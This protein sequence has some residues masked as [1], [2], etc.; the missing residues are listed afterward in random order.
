MIEALLSVELSVIVGDV[1]TGIVNDN[2]TGI[3]Q[4]HSENN[5]VIKEVYGKLLFI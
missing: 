4:C 1:N 3:K 5:T 2:I